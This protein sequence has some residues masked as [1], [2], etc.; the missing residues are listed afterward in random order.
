MKDVTMSV[1]FVPRV[2]WTGILDD[3]ATFLANLGILVQTVPLLVLLTVRH[4]GTQMV[5]VPVGQVG[6][7]MIAQLN[8]LIPMERIVSILAV[9]NALTG[10]VIDSTE[11]VFVMIVCGMLRRRMKHLVHFGLLPSLYHSSS[12][13]YSFLLC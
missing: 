3:I 7:V 10:P 8:V 5:C 1:E 2:V 6:W 12:T 4:V 9:D 11:T 13:L